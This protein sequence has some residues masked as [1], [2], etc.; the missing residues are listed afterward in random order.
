MSSYSSSLSR[1]GFGEQ[2]V[3]NGDLADVVEEAAE[4]NGLEVLRRDSELL[5][6]RDGNALDALRV[7]GG[8]RILRLHGCVQALDRLD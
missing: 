7:A 4:T 2:H 8:V 1:T 5:C 6:D 3:G